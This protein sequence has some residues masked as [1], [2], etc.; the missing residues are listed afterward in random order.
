MKASVFLYFPSIT[1]VGAVP[2][3]VYSL[4][5]FFHCEILNHNDT[6]VLI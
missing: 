4:V 6:E 5:C 2:E 3:F 1:S